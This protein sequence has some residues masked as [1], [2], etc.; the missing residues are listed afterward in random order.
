MGQMK[1]GARGGMVSKIDRGLADDTQG[2]P[3]YFE[4]YVL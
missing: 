1:D 3:S 4:I 2:K